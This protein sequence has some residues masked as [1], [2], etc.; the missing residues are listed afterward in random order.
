MP[1][2]YDK[3][4]AMRKNW[5]H[6]MAFLGILL[7]SIRSASAQFKASETQV[8]YQKTQQ[9][10]V[11][12]NLPY[13]ED[14]VESSIKEYMSR[15]GLKNS[16]SRGYMVFRNVRLDERDAALADLHIRVDRKSSSEKGASI[17]TVLVAGPG[18]D[19]ATRSGRNEKFQEGASRYIENMVPAI[20]AGDL[21]AKIKSQESVT[22]KSQNK[23]AN[24]HDDQADLEKKIRNTQAD[25]EQNKKDQVTET[26]NM[27]QSVHGDD[28]ALKKSHKKMD[29]LLSDQTR[30]QK[31]LA[32]YQ[33]E[34]GQNKRDQDT[35]QSDVQQQQHS[36]DSLR[37]LRKS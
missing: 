24:L 6:K 25:L 11:L 26:N 17:V 36:L 20:Q 30:M 33:A 14:I 13:P 3:F 19:P 2:F 28:A 15:K 21:E 31:K 12:L 9:T 35:Q 37:T 32:E 1:Y 23:M 16:S 27:Q 8:L 7:F 4:Y 22:K 5:L 10:A 34:L 18:E 29:K